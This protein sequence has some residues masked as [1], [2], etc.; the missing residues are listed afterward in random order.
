MGKSFSPTGTR[1][2]LGKLRQQPRVP[3]AKGGRRRL[4]CHYLRQQGSDDCWQSPVGK[5][6]DSFANSLVCQQHWSMLLAN[7]L[8]KAV[9]KEA[10]LCQQ[11]GPKLLAKPTHASGEAQ[12][13]QQPGPKLFAKLARLVDSFANSFGPCCW[14]SWKFFPL[15][16]CCFLAFNSHI[17]STHQHMNQNT[18]YISTI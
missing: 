8:D 2:L 12:L 4:G 7:L 15:F 3:L 13:C 5:G 17:K 11:H 10:Q 6:N 16:F 18:T 14:Q 9:G 1:D